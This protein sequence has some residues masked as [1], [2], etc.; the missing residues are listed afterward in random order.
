MFAN[1][2]RKLHYSMYHDLK[3]RVAYYVYR[4]KKRNRVVGIHIKYLKTSIF[5]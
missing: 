5:I 3:F 1:T 4:W 2:F